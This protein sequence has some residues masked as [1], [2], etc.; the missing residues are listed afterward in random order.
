[1]ALS[2]TAWRCPND[3]PA[4]Q[5]D[6]INLMPSLGIN[7]ALITPE[8]LRAYVLSQAKVVM[9]GGLQHDPED[10]HGLLDLLLVERAVGA[11]RTI[12]Q[13][14]G[15]SDYVWLDR[16]EISDSVGFRVVSWTGLDHCKALESSNRVADRGGLH[17][18][19]RGLCPISRFVMEAGKVRLVQEWI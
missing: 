11:V 14:I 18:E 7:P 5:L 13:S 9:S 16:A 10:E 4:Q 17:L 12:A 8:Q 19:Y 2:A 1:M 15:A 3:R 6:G